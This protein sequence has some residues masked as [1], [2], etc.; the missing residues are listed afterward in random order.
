VT[1]SV[2]F[3]A[4]AGEEAGL[5]HVGRASAIAVALG[6]RG[7]ETNCYAYGAQRP[8][9]LDGVDWLPLEADS[10]S[11]PGNVVVVDSYRAPREL[12]TRMAGTHRLVYMHDYGRAP[13]DAALVVSVAASNDGD[14]RLSGLRYAAL[15]PA[16]WGLP[17]RALGER[18]T[19]VLVTTGSALFAETGAQMARSLTEALA[20][21]TIELVRGPHSTI[22][23]PPG[24]EVLDAPDSLLGPLLA[25]DLVVS[26]AGQTM[27]EA[28]A[29]GTPCVALPL[30]EN[31]RGQAERLA[32]LGAVRLIE[33]TNTEEVAAACYELAHDP[34]TRR[35]LSRNGQHVVDGHGALRIAFQ[36]A[37][38]TESSS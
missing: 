22:A 29:A 7:V 25:A 32:E 36:V 9:K 15:R 10:F 23:V 1:R 33:R 14:R 26:A 11:L 28:A 21:T 30:A 19:R 24:I 2:V 31:Q 5:G 6:C 3:I 37:Q 18:V 35:G 12:I 4:D 38:L 34:E 16:Y 17:A 20:E 8:F 27:L 13:N